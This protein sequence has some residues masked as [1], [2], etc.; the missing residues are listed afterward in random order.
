MGGVTLH[1]RLLDHLR[2]A[3]IMLDH[4]LQVRYLNPAAEM[5][6]AT[7]VSR[8]LGQPLPDYFFDD[9]EARVA[10]RQ[11]MQDEHPFTRREARLAVAPGHEITVDYSVSP[12]N[13]PG[14]PLCLL[15]EM[16]SL[17]RLLRITREEA[18]IHA[19]QATRA[20]VRGVAHEIKNPLGGIRGAAQLLERALPDPELTEYTKVIIDEADRLRTVADRMLGPRKPPEFKPVNVHEC[21]EHVRQLLLAE[22]P[23]GVAIWRDYDISL[24]DVIADR[25]QMI[26]VLLNIIRNATQAL[27]ESHTEDA[28]IVMRTRVLRQFTIGS[29]RHRLVLRVDIIDNGP[30]IAPDVQ[31][32]LFYPMVSGRASGTGLGLSIAQS[33]ISQHQ[34]L[35]E[36][37]SVPGKTVFSILLPM[38]QP[39][40][41]ESEQP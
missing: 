35:I 21:L 27:L 33:I 6:L 5:L 17:D 3:V 15:V 20:L 4:E 2:T 8:A 11:C 36:C 22:H 7:S 37:E 29:Q 38:E 9:E 40:V 1:K 10:L 26:Q 34:G 14:Q 41:T 32:T 16:Q 19:H 24:P 30:G 25:D 13:E 18:L 12:I 39:E 28:R 23:E 31:E